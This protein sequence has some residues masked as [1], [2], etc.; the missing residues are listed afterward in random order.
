MTNCWNVALTAGA[1]VEIKPLRK[2]IL[3]NFAIRQFEDS[4]ASTRVILTVNGGERLDARVSSTICTLSPTIPQYYTEIVLDPNVR[5]SIRTEG[6]NTVS[7]I[8]R[9]C[10]EPTTTPDVAKQKRQADDDQSTDKKQVGAEKPKR[11]LSGDPKSDTGNKS[12]V[13]RPADLDLDGSESKRIRR[14]PD[15]GSATQDQNKGKK[16]RKSTRSTDVKGKGRD[17][18]EGP[19]FDDHSESKA[20]D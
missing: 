9:F 15:A 20:S 17:P 7:I 1:P 18:Q 10:D 12:S 5:C 19:G 2:L 4:L 3:S 13:K 16:L 8:G 6:L 11:R 14:E